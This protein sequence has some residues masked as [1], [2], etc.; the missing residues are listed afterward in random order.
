LPD[1]VRRVLASVQPPFLAAAF[2][3][4]DADYGDLETCLADGLALGSAKR[5]ALQVRYL[6]A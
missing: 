1:D 3:A 6:E 5:S 2:E 4:I